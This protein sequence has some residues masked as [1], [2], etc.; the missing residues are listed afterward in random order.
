M[1]SRKPN[2]ACWTRPSA[3]GPVRDRCVSYRKSV[4]E[5]DF[6]CFQ[7]DRGCARTGPKPDDMIQGLAEQAKSHS[8]H[9]SHK[10]RE[11]ITVSRPTANPWT[12]SRRDLERKNG[13][14]IFALGPAGVGSGFE[15]RCTT[16]KRAC[17]G[18]KHSDIIII[19]CPS[20]RKEKKKHS[21]ISGA[22][23][24]SRRAYAV[25]RQWI[26][27]CWCNFICKAVNYS[28][29][30]LLYQLGGKLH[31]PDHPLSTGR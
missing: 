19:V 18:R 6:Q 20:K 16:A 5:T 4:M 1:N 28:L 26:T 24:R 29:L 12:S 22:G 8:S 2:L 11:I 23:W 9:P 10:A 13:T 14:L 3:R 27:V 15:Q 25:W 7:F 30:I 21:L 17:R 31:F